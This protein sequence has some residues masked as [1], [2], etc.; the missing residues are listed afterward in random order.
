MIR[1]MVERKMGPVAFNYAAYVYHALGDLTRYF[2]SLNGALDE[3]IMNPSIM[4]YSP[5]LAKSR[6]DPRYGELVEKFRMSTGLAD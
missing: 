1:K 5:L 4:M 2:E 3:H 6:E